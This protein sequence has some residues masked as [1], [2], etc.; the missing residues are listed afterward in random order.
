[1]A[2][3]IAMERQI[4]A[5]YITAGHPRRQS[6]RNASRNRPGRPLLVRRS[7][8]HASSRVKRASQKVQRLVASEKVQGLVAPREVLKGGAPIAGVL[9]D[10]AANAAELAAGEVR[11]AA[12]EVLGKRGTPSAVRVEDRARAEADAA[13]AL[14]AIVLA[15]T[16]VADAFEGAEAS[17]GAAASVVVVLDPRYRGD[18]RPQIL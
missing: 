11:A 8:S 3:A 15:K 7:V 6:R 12:R 16:S 10:A 1:M 13:A 17:R 14:D 5:S 2:A 9:T 4:L 18:C